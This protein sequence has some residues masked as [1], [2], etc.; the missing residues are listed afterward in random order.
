MSPLPPATKQEMADNL[1]PL[2]V[3]DS[4][5]NYLIPLNK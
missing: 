5:A 1:V 4:C 3:R 2:H